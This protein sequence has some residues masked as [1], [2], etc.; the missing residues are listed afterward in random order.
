MYGTKEDPFVGL[1]YL[2]GWGFW[3]ASNPLVFAVDPFSQFSKN[4]DSFKALEH[5]PLFAA[6]RTFSVACVSAHDF[7][8]LVLGIKRFLFSDPIAF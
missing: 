8:L 2:S 6:F 5:V 1:R 7:Y 4:I 3:K